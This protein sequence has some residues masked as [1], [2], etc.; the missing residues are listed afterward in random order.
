M[1]CEEVVRDQGSEAEV[2][3]VVE[4]EPDGASL[5]LDAR[6]A[7]FLSAVLDG[8]VAGVKGVADSV[9]GFV[10]PVVSRNGGGS[11]GR[12]GGPENQA[13]NG[14]CGVDI[15]RRDCM[16]CITELAARKKEVC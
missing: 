3:S 14:I 9:C 15:G 1:A 8:E 12:Q 6:A 11:S 2:G 4:A 10:E 16:R 5:A 13:K 7:I